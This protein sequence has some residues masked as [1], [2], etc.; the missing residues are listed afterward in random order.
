MRFLLSNNQK[1]VLSTKNVL[2]T[3]V[4]SLPDL[5]VPDLKVLYI[6]VT[7]YRFEQVV[8]SKNACNGIRQE[9]KDPFTPPSRF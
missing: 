1:L 5:T 9:P 8:S 6:R 2:S 7:V 3:Q 4:L